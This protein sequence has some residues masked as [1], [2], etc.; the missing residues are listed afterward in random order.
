M[1]FCLRAG[2]TSVFQIEKNFKKSRNENSRF[3]KSNKISKIPKNFREILKNK[4]KRLKIK[5]KVD[6]YKKHWQKEENLL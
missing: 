5:Q 2:M 3:E 6:K 4:K 1:P